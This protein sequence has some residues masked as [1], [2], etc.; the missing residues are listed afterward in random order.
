MS[1][2]PEAHILLT[3]GAGQTGA[4]LRRQAPS[5]WRI[6][7]PASSELDIA[8]A[9]QVSAAIGA[10]PWSLVVN[11]AAYTAVDRAEDEVE[12]AWRTN[13]L[14]PAILASAASRAGVPLIHISTD[15]VF[16][17]S[18]PAPY[19]EEDP[20][21]PLGVY[22]ASK[23]GGEQAVRSAQPRH[24]ILRTAW[25]VSPHG[26]NFI[27]TMFRLATERSVLRVVDD[28]RGSPT[29]A[30]DLARALICVGERLISD[31]D[32]P[33]G[34]YHF[35][36]QGEASWREL[37][38]AAFEVRSTHGTPAPEIQAIATADYPTRARRPAN[39]RLSTAKYQ[40]VFGV[41]PRPWKEAISDV[42]EALLA[43]A[44]KVA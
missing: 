30:A 42:V 13:A 4:E 7:A 21:A 31:P 34:T 43:D 38:Q 2:E 26:A 1:D 27:K 3:G 37:A 18:K 44:K 32:A 24:V 5:H 36:N 29:A 8:R 28:Q 33:T 14:G 22:G 41:T 16:D 35:V 17:G 9:D 10:R 25:L 40:R 20:I 15:Y 6:F 19:V 12:A 39:S 11:A 23:E